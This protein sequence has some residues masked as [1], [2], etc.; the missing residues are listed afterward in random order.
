MM[1]ELVSMYKEGAVTADHL[2]A[3]CVQRIDPEN[4]GLVLGALPEEIFGKVLEF[5][6]EYRPD[7][8][9]TNH[10]LLPAVDQVEAARAWISG[11]RN[12]VT[13]DDGSPA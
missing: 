2:V 12:P 11:K 5:V 1:A 6:H 4:P 8:M 13:V 3:E 7:G 9:V 10:G